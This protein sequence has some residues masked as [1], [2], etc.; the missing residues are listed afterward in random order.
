SSV[1]FV[2]K[3]RV[4]DGRQMD[5]QL[6]GAPCFWKEMQQRDCS[7]LLYNLI[8]T[9]SC[10]PVMHAYS[11]FFAVIRMATYWQFNCP[12]RR[13]KIAT[14]DSRIFFVAAPFFE[15]LRQPF[16]CLL[17]FRYQQDA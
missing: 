16:E 5:T 12:R 17:I 11:H 13:M 4:P 8:T 14:S 7:C 6:M 15:S 2:S 10:A 1:D 9:D 3:N